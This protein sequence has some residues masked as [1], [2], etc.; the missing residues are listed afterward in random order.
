[1][2]DVPGFGALSRLLQRRGLGVDV[3]SSSVGGRDLASVLDGG[4]PTPTVLRGLAPAL[5]MHAADLFVIAGLAVPD[6]L[7]PLRKRAAGWLPSIVSAA[8]DEPDVLPGLRDFARSLPIRAPD[9][10]PPP[11]VHQR[12]PPG[13]GGML[14]RL[15]HNRSLDW[16]PSAKI[17][18]HLA[19]IGPLAAATVGMV[20]HD[21]KPLTPELVA[22]FA[23]VT[24]IPAGDLAAL[25]GTDPSRRLVDGPRCGERGCGP[26]L[27]L[28]EPHRRP[29]TPGSRTRTGPPAAPWLGAA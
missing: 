29:A 2:T 10:P 6:D 20:G 19:G 22:G 17:L 7:A 4:A 12:Y 26:D 25:I 24:G 5:G 16:T 15:L 3:L 14:V 8:I 27:G 1:V 28:P 13:F 23:T 11:P 21:R 18:Y 9:P